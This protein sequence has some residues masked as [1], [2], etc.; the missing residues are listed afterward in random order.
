MNVF[1]SFM[2]EMDQARG[3]KTFFMFNLVEHE[4]LNGHK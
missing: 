2:S 4:I 3:N 1:V